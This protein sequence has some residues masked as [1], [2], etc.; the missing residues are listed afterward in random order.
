VHGWEGRATQLG[1]FVAPLTARGFRVL[2]FDAPGHGARPGPALDV[3]AYAQF[4]R[5]VAA[6]VGPLRGLIA[7]S[8]GAAASAFAARLPLRVERAVLIA[9]PRS[10]ADV[11]ARF[12]T[13]LGL[14]PPTRAR[15]RAHL[16]TSLFRAPLAELDLARHVPRYLPPTLLVAADDDADVPVAETQ[17]LAANWPRAHMRI[18]LGAGGHRKVLRDP[19]VIEAAADFI[20]AEKWVARPLVQR[21]PALSDAHARTG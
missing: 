7:H 9:T 14:A 17:E 16:E 3:L 19:G 6:E 18:A 5:G 11:L 15:L 20:G 1:R 8:M 21:A 4:L 13:L 2:G 10:V 12:E